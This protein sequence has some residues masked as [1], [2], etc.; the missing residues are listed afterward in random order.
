MDAKQQQGDIK[1]TKKTMTGH[2]MTT[3]RLEMRQRMTTTRLKT[4]E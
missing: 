3:K 4:T 2:K 1:G